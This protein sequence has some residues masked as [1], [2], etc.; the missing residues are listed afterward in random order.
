MSNEHRHAI[1][2]AER[3]VALASKLGLPEPAR[4]LGFRGAERVWLG[5]AEGLE[6][7]RRALDA[8][9]AQGLG[10][11]VAV[12]YYNLAG[13]L[14][15][16]EGPR[17][18]LETLREGAAHAERRGIE[19]FVLAFAAETTTALDDLG[20]LEEAMT[21]AEGLIPRLLQAGDTLELVSVRSGQ[22]RFLARR[23]EFARADPLIA[24]AAQRA[25]ELADAQVQP[26]AFPIAA[27]VRLG[28]D[29]AGG[30]LRLLEELD[31]APNVRD[32]VNYAANLPDAVRTALAAD[33]PDLAAH[34]AA[35]FEPIYALHQH[36]LLTAQALLAEHRGSH[37]EAAELFADAARG[38]ERFETPW[39]H[40]QAVLGR[41]RCLLAIG[42]TAAARESLRMARRT[43]ASFGARPAL[44]DID[45]LLGRASARGS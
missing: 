5:D 30:A 10:R 39:E 24:W 19:E 45:A 36:A 23:G 28:L 12:L 20:S 32:Q 34:L 40:A 17:A 41:G 29:D 13:A 25:R 4:A 8:A 31:A 14:W 42:R 16:I 33:A 2:F 6:D 3:A 35:G 44:A 38:W 21:L 26:Q 43:F 7:M 27:I 1:A 11:E 37:P 22:A 18:R 15:P 9:S